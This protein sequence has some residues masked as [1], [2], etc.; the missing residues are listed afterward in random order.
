[1]GLKL[2]LAGYPSKLEAWIQYNNG[3]INL[4]I[5]DNQFRRK[6]LRKRNKR[7]NLQDCNCGY[8]LKY[9][10]FKIN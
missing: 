8:F 10:Y 7:G 1:M 3:V 2:G 4:S 9:F 5:R 6:C